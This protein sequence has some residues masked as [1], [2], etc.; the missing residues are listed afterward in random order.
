MP[1]LHIV[2]LALVQGVTEFLPISSSGHLVLV[3]WLAGWPDQGLILDVAVHVGTL[4][5]VMAYLWRDIAAMLGGLWR[6][7]QGKGMNDGVKLAFYLV[8]GTLPVIAA[9]LLMKKYVPGGIRSIEVIGWATLGFGVLLWLVDRFS[10]T[11][12][13]ME[14][15]K[16]FDVAIIGVSQ[17]LA[18]I[19]G[20]SRSGITMTTARLLGMERRDSARFSMLLSIPAI[21][22]A[23]TLMGLELYKIGDPVQID[24]ALAGVAFAFISALVAIALMMAWLK[25]ASFTPFV[26]YRLALGALLLAISYGFIS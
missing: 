6:F 11:L 5:A 16:L 8:L 3:P 7:V 22:G 14:H 21:V 1:I 17:C 4:G 2:I 15:L 18:L 25:H 10:V 19:P 13:R 23:G 12:R 26:I 20:T 9:G 24:A